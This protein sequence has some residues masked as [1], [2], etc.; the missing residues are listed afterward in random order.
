MYQEMRVMEKL[1]VGTN[2]AANL[3]TGRRLVVY[4]D[5][6]A[7]GAVATFIATNTIVDPL[8][9]WAVRALQ[10]SGVGFTPGGENGAIFIQGDALGYGILEKGAPTSRNLLNA[11]TT[12]GAGSI[13]PQSSDASL[14]VAGKVGI[15][16]NDTG[17]ARLAVITDAG[18][19][20]MGALIHKGDASG[21]FPALVV[22]NRTNGYSP[23]INDAG[24]F[25]DASDGAYGIYQT[26]DNPPEPNYFA[27]NVGIGIEAPLAPLHAVSAGNGSAAI[28]SQP[29]PNT[30]N[31][32]IRACKEAV[33]DRGVAA[34]AAILVQNEGDG[35]GIY[36]AGNPVPNYFSGNVGIG[37]ETPTLPLVV[38]PVGGVGGIRIQEG[39]S[40]DDPSYVLQPY[41]RGIDLLRW[42]GNVG[43]TDNTFIRIV[44]NGTSRSTN[45]G[46]GMTN[47]YTDP[48]VRLDVN[49]PI[50]IGA[51]GG[52]AC[53]ANLGGTI[54]FTAKADWPGMGGIRASV[55]RLCSYRSDVPPPN[56][57]AWRDIFGSYTPGD[58]VEKQQDTF[59]VKNAGIPPPEE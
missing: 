49:G 56:D 15:G 30:G 17:A 27:G 3:A 55:L 25:V 1:G 18:E 47:T 59:G 48:R 13:I 44:D 52:E 32:A 36:Q 34:E 42:R 19:D 29:N 53:T 12:I 35:H 33:C 5:S 22:F 31:F 21:T 38:A 9:S 8:G 20:E 16:A 46:I 40:N 11:P 51:Y 39:P 37:T 10:G 7:A 14:F 58:V 4:D 43:N 57:W 2:D 28:F 45:V 26:G 54:R 24:I 50:K 23:A 6:G 41:A